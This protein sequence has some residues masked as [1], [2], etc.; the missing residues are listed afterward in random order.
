MS[1]EATCPKCEKE[2]RRPDGLAGLLEKCPACRFVFRM[3]CLPKAVPPKKKEPE[4]PPAGPEIEER[5]EPAAPAASVEV[6][7][8]Q[9]SAAMMSH[10]ADTVGVV[11]HLPWF[12]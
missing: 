6:N 11:L 3:P 7:A 4:E 1:I 9:Q 5:R 8:P 12:W 10:V 2:F